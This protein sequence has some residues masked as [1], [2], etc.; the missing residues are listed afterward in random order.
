MNDSI[1]M[2]VLKSSTNLSGIIYHFKFSQSLSFPEDLTEWPIFAQIQE[3]IAILLIFEK[4]MELDNILMIQTS[5]DLD[6]LF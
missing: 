3:N 6:L 5:M 1:I 2:Q 4:P